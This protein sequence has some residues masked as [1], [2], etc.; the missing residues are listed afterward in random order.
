MIED[1]VH[2]SEQEVAER[3]EIA[4]DALAC[5]GV[6]LELDQFVNDESK[7]LFLPGIRPFIRGEQH[8]DFSV[9]FFDFTVEEMHEFLCALDGLE[10]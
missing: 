7:R 9:S 1:D 8:F 3:A 2:L 6:A 4:Q 10:R 5:V